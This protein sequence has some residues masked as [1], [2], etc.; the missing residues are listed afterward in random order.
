MET[1]SRIFTIQ[2]SNDESS[3]YRYAKYMI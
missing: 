3:G 1:G 2:L